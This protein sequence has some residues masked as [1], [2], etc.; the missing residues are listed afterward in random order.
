MQVWLQT[1]LLVEGCC[2]VRVALANLLMQ[3]GSVGSLHQAESLDHALWAYHDNQPSVVLLGPSPGHI[4]PIEFAASML[5]A[6][7]SAKVV[8]VLLRND[9][10]AAAAALGAG[11]LGIAGTETAPE[12]LV[13][14]LATAAEGGIYCEHRFDVLLDYMPEPGAAGGHHLA[15]RELRVLAL[16][17]EGKSSKEIASQLGIGVET[18]RQYRKSV[19]RKL[20]VHNVAGL[21][22]VASS[23]NLL[24]VEAHGHAKGAPSGQISDDQGRRPV[25]PDV[26]ER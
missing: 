6:A 13:A 20:S 16:I 5:R 17:G 4:S 9:E 10:E 7:P 19:M 1:L 22:R 25:G 15:P 11:I 12:Q 2:V 26:S 8:A 23:E 3:S 14:A 21:L 18:V 24:R